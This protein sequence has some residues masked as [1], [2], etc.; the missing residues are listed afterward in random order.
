MLT[1]LVLYKT[2]SFKSD[3]LPKMAI[4]KMINI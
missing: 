3:L 2:Q 1:K 4:N